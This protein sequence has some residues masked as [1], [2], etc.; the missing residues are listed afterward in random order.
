[1]PMAVGSQ[2]DDTA[3]VHA[4]LSIAR[5]AVPTPHP[6]RTKLAPWQPWQ[7]AIAPRVSGMPHARQRCSGAPGRGP[8]RGS[9]IDDD[10]L[11]CDVGPGRRRPNHARKWTL[12]RGPTR[13]AS[14]SRSIRLSGSLPC[15]LRVRTCTSSPA[16]AYLL[17]EYVRVGWSIYRVTTPPP[18][19]LVGLG[20]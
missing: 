20:D 19:A 6:Q 8:Q 9:I 12:C 5:S 14:I 18:V 3:S 13:P 16:Y 15:C 17:V 7:E 2:R 4:K 10:S 11:L 1:M